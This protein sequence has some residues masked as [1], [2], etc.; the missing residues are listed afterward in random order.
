MRIVGEYFYYQHSPP[1]SVILTTEHSPQKFA[2]RFEL[3]SGKKLFICNRIKSGTSDTWCIGVDYEKLLYSPFFKEWLCKKLKFNATAS[4]GAIVHQNDLFSEKM[5]KQ[6]YSHLSEKITTLEQPINQQN[7]TER[8]A[9]ISEAGLIIVAAELDPSARQ[10]FALNRELR[11]LHQGWPRLY[12]LGAVFSETRSGQEK[13]ISNLSQPPKNLPRYKFESCI[14]SQVGSTHRLHVWKREETL[15]NQL[16]NGT[17]ARAIKKR[18]ADLQSTDKGLRENAFWDSDDQK[19]NPLRLRQGFAFA[20]D[21]LNVGNINAADVYFAMAEIL[22]NARES[23]TI[24]KAKSLTAQE[25]QQVVIDPE[26]FS[27]F[28]DGIIQAAI[29]RAAHDSELDYRDSRDLSESMS[30]IL[31]EILSGIGRA[32]GEAATEFLVALAIGRMRLM[33]AVHANFL[34]EAKRQRNALPPHCRALLRYLQEQQ[35]KQ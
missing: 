17:G 27:R 25:L 33:P 35:K 14:L 6:V 8:Q 4:V 26:T 18:L 5:A 30:R 22:Q 13:L 32:A 12:L 10:M 3:I 31:L 23:E 24:S 2:S 1:R 20:S 11:N 9:S 34:N 28:D 15:L 7:I 19:G 16:K 29:L 21:K